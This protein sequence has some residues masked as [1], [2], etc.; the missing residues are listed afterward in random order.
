MIG[1]NALCICH[2]FTYDKLCNKMCL[3]PDCDLV[4]MVFM[5]TFLYNPLGS[6]L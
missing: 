1:I 2:I 3:S 4:V 5:V 6:G